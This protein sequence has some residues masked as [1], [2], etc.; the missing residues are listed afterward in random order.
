M[1]S[2]HKRKWLNDVKTGYT[3]Y[4][5]WIVQFP[6]RK[7]NIDNWAWSELKI[8]DCNRSI[9]LSLDMDNKSIKGTV[10]KLQILIDELTEL[11]S[12]MLLAYNKQFELEKINAKKENKNARK[13]SEE[14]DEVS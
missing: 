5:Q 12:T 13:N 11:K 3:S 4:I 7:T 2:I 14:V 6:D 9:S 8:G 1:K 10:N